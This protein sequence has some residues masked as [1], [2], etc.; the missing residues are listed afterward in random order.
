MLLPYRL[1]RFTPDSQSSLS[2]WWTTVASAT[3]HQLRKE[4][5]SLIILVARCLWLE[6]NNRVFDKVAPMPW[7]VCGKI[8]DEF[9]LWKRAKLRGVEAGE[10]E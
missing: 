2:V 9:D 10:I 5:N 4:I 6:R 3:P 7:T 1:H 8:R